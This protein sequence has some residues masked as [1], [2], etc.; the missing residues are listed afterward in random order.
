MKLGNGTL[1]KA[2]LYLLLQRL[3]GNAVCLVVV[4]LLFTAIV[5]VFNGALHTVGYLVG[6]HYSLAIYVARCPSYRL[7]KRTRRAQKALFIGIENSYKRHFRQVQPLAE[8]VYPYE[9]IKK[10]FAEVLHNLYALQSI[11]IAVY[12]TAAHPYTSKVFGEF[13]SHTLGK[14]RYEYALVFLYAYLYFFHKVV[15]LI[16][17]W[18]DFYLG[19]EQPCRAY[20]LLY[21]HPLRFL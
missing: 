9:H 11:D 16:L 21:I 8:E 7:G 10:S 2:V 14:G 4:H 19:V 12:I 18:A 5:S 15:Y 1:A 3:W 6:I 13:L 17:A 20:H